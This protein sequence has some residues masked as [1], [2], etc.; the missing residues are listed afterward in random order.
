MSDQEKTDSYQQLCLLIETQEAALRAERVIVQECF[1][2]TYESFRP[3]N[4][5]KSTI[6]E[7]SSPA[8]QS[9][10]LSTGL[11]LLSQFLIRKAVSACTQPGKD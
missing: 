7:I 1:R 11:T 5:I 8:V 9:G 2:A 4:L 3:V 10:I 6:E